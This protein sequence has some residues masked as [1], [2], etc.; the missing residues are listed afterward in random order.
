MAHDEEHNPNP[1]QAM[2]RPSR[3]VR[4]PEAGYTR[5]S[6]E[7][8]RR[9]LTSVQFKVTRQDGT[10][11]RFQQPVLGQPRAWDI[12]R[13]HLRRAALQLNRQVRFRH[14]VAEL[15]AAARAGEHRR[16]KRPQLLRGPNRGAQQTCRFSP[17]ARVQRRPGTD[18]AA[19]LHEL[20]GTALCVQ[21]G[22]GRRLR[23]ISRIVP[24]K[25]S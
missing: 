16:E 15:H 1:A 8:L 13:C 3:A 23:S 19:L 11:P 20:G 6:D 4:H 7:D 24:L 14:R 22:T 2:S 21:G 9:R 12:R 5:P 17:G 25:V 18:R 10:E